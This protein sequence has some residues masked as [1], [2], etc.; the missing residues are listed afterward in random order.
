[1]S[2]FLCPEAENFHILPLICHQDLHFWFF[3]SPN[4]FNH[5]WGSLINSERVT[6]KVSNYNNYNFYDF[7][8]NIFQTWPFDKHWH[9]S[10]LLAAS[11][12]FN[13]MEMFALKD[14]EQPTRCS[15]FLWLLVNTGAA[16]KRFGIDGDRE[17]VPLKLELVYNR[18]MCARFMSL[19][20]K[21]HSMTPNDTF[22]FKNLII[23]CVWVILL[24]SF[25]YHNSTCVRS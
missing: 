21:T 15:S 22:F 5:W 9:V 13:H 6:L 20:S 2:Y 19:Y 16:S 23:I 24:Y 25:F 14:C 3:I 7:M 18:V 1:M 11:I 17:A 12:I 10:L 4:R 8:S